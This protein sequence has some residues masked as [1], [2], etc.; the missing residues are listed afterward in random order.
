MR[1]R[2]T[3]IVL[4]ALVGC[5]HAASVSPALESDPS[6]EYVVTI[7][8]NFGGARV[9]A[10]FDGFAPSHLS[11]IDTEAAHGLR[12][13]WSERG[14]LD[15]HAGRIDLPA[16]MGALCVSY[17]TRFVDEVFR[18]RDSRAVVV[19]QGEWLW[20]PEPFPSDLE[21]S[22]SIALPPDA[23]ASLPWARNGS[24]YYPDRDAFYQHS[25]NVFG[26]FSEERFSVAGMPVSV[27]RLGPK[28][29]SE[30]VRHWLVGSIGAAA[31]VG[32]SFPVQRLHFVVVPVDGMNRPVAFGM[33]RRGG[34]PSVLL[35]A[36]STAK[37]RDLET[38]WVAIHELSHLWLPRLYGKDRWLAEGI[39][40]YLQ[41]I[42][43]A[44]CGLQSGI[45]SWNLI[46]DGLERG[47]GSGT[48]QILTSESR[49][50]HRTRAYYRVYWAGTAFA[51]EADLR[52]RR[53]SAGE[54]TLLRALNLAQSRLSSLPTLVDAEDV[55]TVL[56]EVSG[57]KFL[58]ELGAQY[59]SSARFPATELLDD[60]ANKHI[61]K[62]IMEPDPSRCVLSVESLQ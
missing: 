60:P 33:V 54:M 59:A 58:V 12:R 37:A 49:D 8:D 51:L 25:Y 36:S 55:L 17:E 34:G 14:A 29:P 19:S 42:L 62:K 22:V 44:R 23:R 11:P 20:R 30:V 9:Y 32:S 26:F 6:A 21:A 35:I 2:W 1:R 61:R 45:V 24:L 4:T 43:R 3:F 28:P 53:K 18:S 48:G 39:A 46:R 50:M 27:A 10:C 41:E 52:L 57:S 15:I 31:S 38:D 7:F 47:R 56:D 5:A 13:A 16:A 40:T